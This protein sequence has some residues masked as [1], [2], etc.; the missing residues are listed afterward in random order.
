MVA[1]RGAA[2]K[3]PPAGVPAPLA[4]KTHAIAAASQLTQLPASPTSQP[5]NSLRSRI[6]GCQVPKPRILTN[7]LR[8][9]IAECQ[10]PKPRCLSPA[11]NN[12]RSR[13]AGC[14]LPKP[15]CLSPAANSLY[16]RI[17]G[18][19]VPKPRCLSPAATKSYFVFFDFNSETPESQKAVLFF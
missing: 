16:S 14:Q 17:A 3:L 8:S 13:I 1:I 15:R 2:A 9:R 10:V 11:D 18:R 7:S 19:Q 12:L 6:A 4:A 5:A